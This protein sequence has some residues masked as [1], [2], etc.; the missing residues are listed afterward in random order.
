MRPII[1]GGRLLEP[2]P[3]LEQARARAAESLAKLPP[4]LRELEAGEPWPIVYSRELR[5]LFERTRQ[6]LVG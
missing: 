2:L 5:E 6:N 1:L 4:A 3:S